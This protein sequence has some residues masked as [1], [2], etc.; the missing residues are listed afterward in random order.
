MIILL[1]TTDK[2][3]VI[4]SAAG[5]ID[6]HCSYVDWDTATGSAAS[7][8][9]NTTITTAATTDISGSPAAGKER[10]IRRIA[11]NNVH[12]SIPNTITVQIVGNITVDSKVVTLLP[13]EE[14]VMGENGVWYQYDAAGG[15]KSAAS[16]VS[17]VSCKELTADLANSTV[18]AAK[19][20][21][22]DMNVPI[23]TWKFEY[24]LRYQSAATTTGFKASVNHTGTVAAFMSLLRYV[25]AA[26]TASTG[27]PSQAANA[28]TAQVMG[29]YS[30]RAKSQAAGMGPTLSVDAATS[31]MLAVLEGTMV[32]T[33]G[34]NIELWFAS[35]V[36]AS[37]I[38]M[39]AGSGLILT[40]I[41]A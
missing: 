32:V 31:D 3:Q 24:W 9:L 27:A 14:L 15:V 35:E 2:V 23:G 33:A 25:D 19:V 1:P 5:D 8:R 41:S 40:R 20:T 18:T 38:T 22:L 11:F 17:P 29:A 39:K 21:G 26:A 12:A 13:G 28:S 36:A 4:T 34:G 7:G 30:A 10:N 6:V 37:A 16:V